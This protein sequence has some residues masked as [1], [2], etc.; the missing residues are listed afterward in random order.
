MGYYKDYETWVKIQMNTAL[1]Q[2][3]SSGQH[4]I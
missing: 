2:L 4:I 3:Y 1:Y